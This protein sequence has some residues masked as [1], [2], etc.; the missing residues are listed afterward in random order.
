MV[1]SKTKPTG[2]ASKITRTSNTILRPRILDQN[3]L[4][5]LKY[6]YNLR[7][8]LPVPVPAAAKTST[9]RVLPAS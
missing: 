9:R 8:S 6:Y 5:Y 1:Q 3:M 2:S 7:R 4:A